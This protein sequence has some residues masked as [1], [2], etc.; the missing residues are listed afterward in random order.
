MGR[1]AWAFLGQ[2]LV[3][4]A[5]LPGPSRACLQRPS[6]CDLPAKA[7]TGH[8]GR[9]YKGRPAFFPAVKPPPGACQSLVVSLTPGIRVG[10]AS[11]TQRGPGAR[12]GCVPSACQAA[13]CCLAPHLHAA[14]Q[15][16]LPSRPV[17]RPMC[18]TLAGRGRVGGDGDGSGRAAVAGWAA[19]GGR[20]HCARGCGQ[21]AGLQPAQAR[22]T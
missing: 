3:W 8:P 4:P 17:G 12:A 14:V 15:Q 20:S 2:C 11:C 10:A 21:E 9:P 18:L 13:G 19:G 5:R 6:I 1:M 7:C 22:R 16:Q